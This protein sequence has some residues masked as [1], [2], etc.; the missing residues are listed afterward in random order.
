MVP[1]FEVVFVGVR[2]SGHILTPLFCVKERK[3]YRL[4]YI[5]IYNYID[6][7]SILWENVI[8]GGMFTGAGE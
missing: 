5:Y 8:G 7:I 3:T 4:K 6:C 1:S 2:R